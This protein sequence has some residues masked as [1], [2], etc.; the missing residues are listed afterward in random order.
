MQ[1]K[2]SIYF[3]PLRSKYLLS[4]LFS[5]TCNTCNSFKERGCTLHM[6]KIVVNRM[7]GYILFYETKF[8]PCLFS[9]LVW[10]CLNHGQRI[11]T[12][13][14]NDHKMSVQNQHNFELTQTTSSVKVP[15]TSGM[16]GMLQTMPCQEELQRFWRLRLSYR[17]TCIRYAGNKHPYTQK[18]YLNCVKKIRLHY[19]F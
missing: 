2:F 16:H 1:Y 18:D 6:W 12:A 14:S 9:V 5:N 4:T 11:V 13:S 19:W 10:M 15:M 3:G 8:S 7:N 17:C